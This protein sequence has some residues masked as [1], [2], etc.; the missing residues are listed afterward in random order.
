M[1]GQKFRMKY[2]TMQLLV[3]NADNLLN[4][5]R[6]RWTLSKLEKISLEEYVDVNN[7]DTFCYWVETKTISL[8]SIKG[9]P[10]NKFGIYKRAES[11]K[12]PI[13]GDF[14]YDE[15]YVWRTKFGKD[16][17]EA[18]ETVINLVIQT[19]HFAMQKNF[20]GIDTINDLN[21]M[22]KWKIAFLFSQKNLIPIFSKLPLKWC[23]KELN[24][25][26]FS[27]ARISDIQKFLMKAKPRKFDCFQFAKNLYESF[28]VW[29]ERN[30]LNDLNQGTPEAITSG[31]EGKKKKIYTTTYERN[32]KLRSKAVIIHG[33]TCA[34]CGFNFETI[35]GKWG[36]GY[37][38]VHHLKPLSGRKS[39]A[40]VN[41]T[42]DL[43]VLCANCHAMV[44]RKKVKTLSISQ[45]KTLLFK[46]DESAS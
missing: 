44:H 15:Q 36:E 11:S 20:R 33:T 14:S 31:F 30:E 24:M 12:L 22:F 43:I 45:L 38:Q 2:F 23:A 17:H 28:E 29:R 25:P 7:K 27:N 35:Y 42:K 19:V 18:F 8:G 6:K 34:A 1:S 10:S 3:K 46:A 4:A 41:P 39:E 21:S 26:N 16:R 9:Y 37:I 40:E 13:S 5:F 32:A